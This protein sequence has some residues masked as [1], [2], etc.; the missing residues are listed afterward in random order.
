MV[1]SKLKKIL[2]YNVICNG[3]LLFFVCFIFCFLF[4]NNIKGNEINIDCSQG[5]WTMT[6]NIMTDKKLIRTWDNVFTN[7]WTII[8]Q[9]NNFIKAV[10][11][12]TKNIS[13]DQKQFE[14]EMG[15]GDM[16][17]IDLMQMQINYVD[18]LMP[19]TFEGIAKCKKSSK[20][21]IKSLK[22]IFNRGY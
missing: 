4:S 13:R 15:L 22:Y 20:D 1:N 5:K 14:E 3:K 2:S 8:F 16:I 12:Q 18:D 19:N 7:Y 11:R 10:E 9:K 17:T 21:N 6:L